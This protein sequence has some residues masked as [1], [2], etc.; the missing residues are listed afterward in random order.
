MISRGNIIG[1]YGEIRGGG[2]TYLEADGKVGT[3]VTPRIEAV[4]FTILCVQCHE[5]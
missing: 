2:I 4:Q 3:Y 1:G 5:K